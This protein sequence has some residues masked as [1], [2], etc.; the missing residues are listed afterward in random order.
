MSRSRYTLRQIDHIMWRAEQAGIFSL[1]PGSPL[2]GILSRD[3]SFVSCGYDDEEIRCMVANFL[4]HRNNRTH[5]VRKLLEDE[6]S[7]TT[8]PKDG[9][10]SSHL[11]TPDMT[12]NVKFERR[13]FEFMARVLAG[14]TPAV[15]GDGTSGWDEFD[16]HRQEIAEAFA[17]RLASTNPNFD[18][19]KF[20]FACGVDT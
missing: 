8:P 1:R 17:D 18:R 10:V 15:V 14:V 2:L 20:L 7:L 12:C 3:P 9:N 4:A 6:N 16:S 11:G 19:G 13:H 5:P